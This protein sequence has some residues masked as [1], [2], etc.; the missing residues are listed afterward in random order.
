MQTLN[1]L[2]KYNSPLLLCKG[3]KGACIHYFR[4]ENHIIS[5]TIDTLTT[6]EGLC[7]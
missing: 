6:D 2:L 4:G 7:Y 3:S 5:S 1:K